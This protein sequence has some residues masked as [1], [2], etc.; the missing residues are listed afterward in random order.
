VF[1]DANEREFCGSYLGNCASISAFGANL[2]SSFE[3][4]R[5]SSFV[6]QRRYDELGIAII[7]EEQPGE[8]VRHG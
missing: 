7:F 1:A 6:R 5:S 4:S 3:L 2:T 8:V